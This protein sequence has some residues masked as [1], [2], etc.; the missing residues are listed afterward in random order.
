VNEIHK[1]RPDITKDTIQIYMKE[2][3]AHIGWNDTMRMK[4]KT[5]D[6]E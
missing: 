4:L 1:R 5:N 6:L 2:W 3:V